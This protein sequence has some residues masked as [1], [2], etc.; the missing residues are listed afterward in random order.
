MSH[1]DIADLAAETKDEHRFRDHLVAKYERKRYC[2]QFV[3]IALVHALSSQRW[4]ADPSTVADRLPKMNVGNG[5]ASA[6]VRVRTPTPTTHSPVARPSA[7]PASN[8]MP[9][10]KSSDLLAELDF[11][12]GSAATA[13]S[14]FSPR[15]VN[16]SVPQSLSQPSFAN[17]QNADFFFTGAFFKR[18]SHT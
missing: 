13:S 12:G 11:F 16:S 9:I 18:N 1:Y 17:F 14:A 8:S 5:E 4:Y 2:Y 15:K 6:A 3:H 10:S 7:Q